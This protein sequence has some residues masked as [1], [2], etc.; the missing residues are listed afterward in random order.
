[1]FGDAARI[2]DRLDDNARCLLSAIARSTLSF[3]ARLHTDGMPQDRRGE[4]VREVERCGS[5][6]WNEKQCSHGNNFISHRPF[7]TLAGL[8]VV[9]LFGFLVRNRRRLGNWW[10]RRGGRGGSGV[11][12]RRSRQRGKLR[13]VNGILSTVRCK[14]G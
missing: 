5:M 8:L 12:L 14:D 13:I 6:S 4:N 10:A 3:N 11:G 9:G 7:C 2:M 1:R